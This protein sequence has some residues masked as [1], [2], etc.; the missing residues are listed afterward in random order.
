MSVGMHYQ[1]ATLNFIRIDS[2]L[3]IQV[4]KNVINTFVVAVPGYVYLLVRSRFLKIIGLAK[5]P[6]LLHV[7][8]KHLVKYTSSVIL[9][10]LLY[11]TSTIA[12]RVK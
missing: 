3:N 1:P 2:L 6:L 9:L 7:T 11:L 8:L 10:C 5:K 12:P 4:I